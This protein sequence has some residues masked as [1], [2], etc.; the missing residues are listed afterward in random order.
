VR[1]DG[2]EWLVPG[3]RPEL[4]TTL[5][6]SLPKELR[7]QLV[8]APEVAAQALARMSPRAAPLL[9]ALE[10][11]LGELRGVQIPLAAWNLDRLPTHL[12]MHFRVE[13]EH[14]DVLAAGDELDALRE[15]VRPRLRDELRAAAPE[16]E[17][18]G[19]TA[20]TIGSLPRSVTVPGTGGAVHAYPAL[21]DEQVAVG[22][23][24]FDTPQAQAAAMRL[25]TRR[26][27]LLTMPSTVRYALDH[28]DGATQLA[29]ATAPQGTLVDALDAACDA[30]VIEGGGPAWDEAAFA[31]LRAHVAGNLAQRTATLL[32]VVVRVL[33]AE[34]EVRARLEPLRA[35]SVGPLRDARDDIERQLARLIHPGFVADAGAARL[36]DLERYLLAAVRRLER[37]IE[38]PAADRARMAV[39]EELEQALERKPGADPDVRWLIEELRVAEFA[40]ALGTREKVSA[41]RIRRA[42]GP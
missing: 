40:Q 21:V 26:L 17:R 19:L 35:A 41:K 13:D 30:L 27:L 32:A 14:G 22:V 16:L 42:L 39:I 31:A 33:A 5:L 28:V 1:P 9:D 10:R 20:W 7:R 38:S 11:A 12:R 4:V 8:P 18:H 15:A 24:A 23:R 36:P 2:F 37:L 6:R 3:L 25:G 34:R 29:L